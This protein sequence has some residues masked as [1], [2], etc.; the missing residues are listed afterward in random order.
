MQKMFEPRRY[1][2]F[3]T[4]ETE[5]VGAGKHV[6][7]FEHQVIAAHGYCKGIGP[8][9]QLSKPRPGETIFWYRADVGFVACSIASDQPPQKSDLI[10]GVS[11]EH[12]RIVEQLQV[13][14]D[15]DVVTAAEVLSA[16]GQ[17]TSYRGIVNEIHSPKIIEYLLSRFRGTKPKPAS[18]KKKAV[19]WGGGWQPDPKL[20]RKVEVTAVKFVT[21]IYKREGWTV[22]SVERL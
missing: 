6:A 14:P 13:L 9:A 3:N 7:M 5:T 4:D 17:V 1:W 8:K 12:T 22:K 20:R 15:A 19:V 2:F 11:D 10:F 18:K 16:T 21:E